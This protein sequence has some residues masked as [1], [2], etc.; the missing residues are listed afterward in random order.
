MP[1]PDGPAAGSGNHSLNTLPRLL[2]EHA[3]VRPDRPAMRE[4]D[5][6]IWQTWSWSEMAAEIESLAAGLLTLGLQRGQKIAVIGDNRPR[7]Y[8]S[9]VAA[10][11]IGAIPVPLYQDAVALE[12]VYV[13]NDADIAMAVVEDQEQVDKLL[14]I[15]DDCPKLHHII[16]DDPRGLGDYAQ[17]YVHGFGRVQEA[18]KAYVA[19]HPGFFAE[20]VERTRGEDTAIILYTSGTTGNPKGVM[21][22]HDNLVITAR[23][24]VEQEGLSADEEVLAYLPMAWVGDNT[25]SL[26]QSYVAGFCVNCQ[27]VPRP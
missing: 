16:Y 5:L 8:W 9:M 14:E 18:G 23:N 27:R 25:F 13:L 21:L 7:L 3:R 20:G 11:T 19:E 6:G 2:V 17:P 15:R 26:A 10:Q 24:G 1:E 12:M 22:S 4:K